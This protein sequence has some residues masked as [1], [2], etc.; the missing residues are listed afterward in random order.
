MDTIETVETVVYKSRTDGWKA[1]RTVALDDIG[2][3][4]KIVIFS[5]YRNNRGKL[6]TTARVEHD[7]GDSTT[8]MLFFDYSKTIIAS[9][10]SRVTSKVV[11][12]QHA[13]IDLD[14][15]KDDIIQFYKLKE[16]A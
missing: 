8:H 9:S 12:A 6:V 15:I 2:L 10:P 16:Q 13:Q 4:S 11:E 14:A 3:E 5:T 1:R 7:N